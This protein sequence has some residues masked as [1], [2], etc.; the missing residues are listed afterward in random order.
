MLHRVGSKRS[1][2]E[3]HSR[4]AQGGSKHHAIA[5]AIAITVVIVWQIFL[6]WVIPRW[7]CHRPWLVHLVVE[8]WW[9]Y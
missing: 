5:V 8:L 6:G 2:S 7:Q 9:Q 3:G 4:A 1:H